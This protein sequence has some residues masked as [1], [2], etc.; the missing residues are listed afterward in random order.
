MN[1]TITDYVFDWEKIGYKIL[2]KGRFRADVNIYKRADNINVG[3]FTMAFT[4]K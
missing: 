3:C 1:S 2:P 4:N